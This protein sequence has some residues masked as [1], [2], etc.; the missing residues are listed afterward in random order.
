M[1]FLV[2]MMPLETR[3]VKML[4]KF[5][6][7]KRIN[8]LLFMQY[9]YGKEYSIKLTRHLKFILHIGII[10]LKLQQFQTGYQNWITTIIV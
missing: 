10:K 9:L 2:K 8:Q 3:M 7:Q 5:V 6:R 1:G 4:K